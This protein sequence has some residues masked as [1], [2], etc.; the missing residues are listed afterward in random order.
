VSTHCQAFAAHIAM[1][2]HQGIGW[3]DEAIMELIATCIA[4][5]MLKTHYEFVRADLSGICFWPCRRHILRSPQPIKTLHC[6]QPTREVGAQPQLL[7]CGR[8][9]CSTTSA[10][11]PRVTPR[12]LQVGPRPIILPATTLMTARCEQVWREWHGPHQ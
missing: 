3:F 5:G 2:A 9:P 10:L 8:R 7:C 12:T 11:P 6:L 1:H 4:V